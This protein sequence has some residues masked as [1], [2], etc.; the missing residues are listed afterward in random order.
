MA[1]IVSIIDG[2]CTEKDLKVTPLS[3]IDVPSWYLPGKTEEYH[4]ISVTV[5]GVQATIWMSMSRA[6]SLVKNYNK[7]YCLC[8]PDC[9]VTWSSGKKYQ[10]LK[11]NCNNNNNNNNNNNSNN[12]INNFVALVCDQTIPTRQPPIVRKVSANFC[13]QCSATWSAW[14]IPMAVISIIYWSHYFLFQVAPQLY[15]GGW[16]PFQTH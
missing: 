16:V 12:N 4:K 11:G 8:L 14:R 3:T 15:S 13:G 6:T 2:W 10:H 9:V 1:L 5:T 7:R